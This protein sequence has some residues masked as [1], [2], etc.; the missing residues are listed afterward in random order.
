MNQL[1]QNRIEAL[2]KARGK[3]RYLREQND[4]LREMYKEV[5][6]Y[7]PDVTS[8]IWSGASSRLSE[9]IKNTIFSKSVLRDFLKYGVKKG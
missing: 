1:R 8:W 6:G 3:I 5:V 2:A 9:R 4:Y 7:E